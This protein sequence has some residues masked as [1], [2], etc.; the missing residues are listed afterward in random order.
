MKLYIVKYDYGGDIDY[1]WFASDSEEQ[2]KKDIRWL[3]DIT[4]DMEDNF[5]VLDVYDLSIGTFGHNDKQ[6]KVVLQE[7]K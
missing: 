4:D 2:A 7:V 3:L 6:Y 5:E 1:E